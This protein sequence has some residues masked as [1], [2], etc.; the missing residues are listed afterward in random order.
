MTE[1]LAAIVKGMDP[2]AE[3]ITTAPTRIDVIDVTRRNVVGHFA[4]KRFPNHDVYVFA[5]KREKDARKVF[6]FGLAQHEMHTVVAGRFE[7]A[8]MTN[9][10]TNAQEWL[11]KKVPEWNERYLK[12]KQ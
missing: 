6:G 12:T 5:C 10:A 4:D 8:E 9:S 3:D 11:A 2:K 7:F 1:A